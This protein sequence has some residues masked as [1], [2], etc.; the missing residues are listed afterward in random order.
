M[1][2]DIGFSAPPRRAGASTAAAPPPSTFTSSRF[3]GASGGAGGGAGAFSESAAAAFGRKPAPESR[4][5][6]DDDDREPVKPTA[7]RNTIAELLTNILPESEPAKP[8]WSKSALQKQRKE[9]PKKAPAAPKSYDEE[10]PTLGG[11]MAVKAA[12]PKPTIPTPAIPATSFAKLATNWAQAEEEHQA[13]EARR[14]HE[15]FEQKRRDALEATERRRFYS[16][17]HTHR[18]PDYDRESHDREG[19]GY[20]LNDDT[21]IEGELGEYDHDVAPRRCYNDH[22]VPEEEGPYDDEEEY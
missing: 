11:G 14:A 17:V 1:S 8:N 9:V 21:Y 15:L 13:E 16:S 10:F 6:F 3:G 2:S 22:E 4:R 12:I 18:R 19:Y 7:P 5:Q 20:D